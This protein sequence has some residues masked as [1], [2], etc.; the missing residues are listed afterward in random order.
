MT[1]LATRQMISIASSEAASECN[2]SETDLRRQLVR[3]GRWAYRLGYTPGTAGNLSVR[4][5]RDLILAT[6]TGCRK[7]PRPESNGHGESARREGQVPP[8]IDP[9]R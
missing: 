5:D 3:Y 4:L 8:R 7:G 1:S 2:S 9:F 6:P